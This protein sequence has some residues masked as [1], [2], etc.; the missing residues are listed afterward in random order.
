MLQQITLVQN[1]TTD[2]SDIYA[3]Q[4]LTY[5]AVHQIQVFHLKVS[6]KI[7]P[8]VPPEAAHPDLVIVL[9][10]DGTFLRTARCFVR[11]HVPLV[12]VNTGTLGFL[13]Y[14]NVNA[15]DDYLDRLRLGDY[16]LDER[17]MLESVAGASSESLASANAPVEA[18]AMNDVVVKNANPS[19]L[20]TLRLYVNDVPVAIYDADGLILST[21]SGSTAYT[22]AAGGPVISPEVNA[23][24]I[25]P[26]CPHSFSAKAVVVPLDKV[27][28]VESATSNYDVVY[29]LDGLESG[30][31]KAGQS[32]QITRSP[33]TCRMVRF[34]QEADD[35]YALLKRKLH[36][37][38][39]PRWTATTERNNPEEI[40]QNFTPDLIPGK[41][42]MH[43]QTKRPQDA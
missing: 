27:F 1:T 41:P 18:L 30:L 31:L 20:C 34:G 40:A 2:P 33:L 23:I 11:N 26:I 32:L 43:P 4:V 14:I 15:L 6:G 13:T 28:R 10:G 35:F 36:W 24:A 7:A 12:G 38:M 22:M 3:S 21:P 39:N 5:C 25:T 8:E 29:A 16:T 9:G 42:T 19:Q 17:V 37:A